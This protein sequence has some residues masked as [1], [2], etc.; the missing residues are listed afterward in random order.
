[1]VVA[2]AHSIA[3]LSR[4]QLSAGLRARASQVTN[5]RAHAVMA[6]SIDGGVVLIAAVVSSALEYR[7]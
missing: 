1:V 6:R 5:A 2:Y 4:R 3:A 7:R